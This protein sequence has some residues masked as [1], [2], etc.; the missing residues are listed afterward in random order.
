MNQGIKR[1]FLDTEDGQILYRI[2]SKGE[3]LLLL[4]MTPRNFLLN[5]E[6]I[7]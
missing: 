3:P 4:H 6:L 5:Q 7:K 1:A 2:D